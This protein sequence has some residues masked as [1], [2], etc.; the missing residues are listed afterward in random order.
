MEDKHSQRKRGH[1]KAP[2]MDGM[3]ASGRSL[4]V[5]INRAYQPNRAKQTPSLGVFNNYANDGFY[6]AQQTARGADRAEED[7][8]SLLEEPIE[9]GHIEPKRSKHSKRPKHRRLKK[10]IKRTALVMVIAVLVGAGY[11][12]YKL[13]HTQKKVLAGGGK[14]AAVCSDDVPLSELSKEGDSRINI[15][16]LGIGG[17]G[18]DGANLT[19]T[20]MLASIDPISN[21]ATRYQFHVI[22]GCIFQVTAHKKLMPP[23]LMR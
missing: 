1:H 6:P 7:E 4:G 9:L 15:L 18:H 5:P 13:Y 14:A 19:D 8:A 16:L 20:I 22:F 11:F 2:S 17:P 23:M 3:V 21:K 10:I 12:S